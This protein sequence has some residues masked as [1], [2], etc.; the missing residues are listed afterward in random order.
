M[1]KRNEGA[2]VRSFA[3][4]AFHRTILSPPIRA[5]RPE[6]GPYLELRISHKQTDI[7]TLLNRTPQRHTVQDR[8]S[9]LSAQ[10]PRHAALAFLM[11][12]DK[13]ANC[14]IILRLANKLSFQGKSS[15]IVF[16]ALWGQ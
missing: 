14:K 4:R 12:A 9:C 3:L 15:G 1:E 5:D 13:R 6:V 7:S 11:L 16:V 10:H 8:H 2:M